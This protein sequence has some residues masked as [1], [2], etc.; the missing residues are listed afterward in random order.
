MLEHNDKPHVTIKPGGRALMIPSET[1]IIGVAGDADA[2]RINFDLPR[3]YD[4]NDLGSKTWYIDVRNPAGRYDAALPDVMVDAEQVH[5]EFAVRAPH[6]AAAGGVY[7]RLRATDDA[8]FTWQS[9]DG[10]FTLRGSKIERGEPIPEPQITAIDQKLGE[11]EDAR[12]TVSAA[13]AQ[14]LA[15]GQ[16]AIAAANDAVDDLAATALRTSASAPWFV[17]SG[18]PVQVRAARRST[19]I[20]TASEAATVT[21]SGTDGV[22][23]STATLTANTPTEIRAPDS[24]VVNI[25]ASSGQLTVQYNRDTG[26]LLRS[27]TRETSDTGPVA[28]LHPIRDAPIRT[29]IEYEATQ[30]GTGDPS[31]D[32]VRPIAGWDAVSVKRCGKNLA[33]VFA[34][35]EVYDKYY[36]MCSVNNDSLPYGKLVTVSFDTP[37]SGITAYIDGKCG[38]PK[39]VFTLDGSRKSFTG[40][41]GAKNPTQYNAVAL[42]SRNE[43]TSET[44]TG[45]ISNVQIEIGSVATPYEPY[46]GTAHDIALPE[47]VYGLPSAPA[48]Y[49]SETGIVTDPT[50]CIASY[51]G[52]DVGDVWMSS[53]G[54]LTTGAQVVYKLP[55]PRCIPVA[56]LSL[57]GLDGETNVCSNGKRITA[58]S[59]E[60]PKWRADQ[61]DARLAALE[62]A[63]TSP[64]T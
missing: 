62:T 31:P 23:T 48:V 16:A 28:T 9:E 51:N 40:K 14:A 11:M 21:I 34:I 29:R 49:D 19:L 53:T 12:Q 20:V 7:L 3:W 39:T 45:L 43:S 56:P 32:N 50:A 24:A 18:N 26:D 38:L 63:V 47:P 8:G 2:E 13:A 58:A 27:L 52:E 59:L 25:L 55:S 33:D 1:K 44:S 4:G 60:N 54:A 36:M 10:E 64:T 37:N 30:A 5:L 17:A 41:V 61:I 6:A 57:G 46:T 15:D 22:T 35:N 42:V